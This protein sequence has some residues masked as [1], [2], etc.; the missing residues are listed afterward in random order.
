MLSLI[1][2]IIKNPWVLIGLG[3]I[4]GGLYLFGY[5]NGRTSIVQAQ[6]IATLGDAKDAT[7]TRA[8]VARLS[9][10]AVTKQ[11]RSRWQR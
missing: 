1:W 11:L 6:A 5:Y 8:N 2:T 9:D 7:K 10:S 4:M 3:V